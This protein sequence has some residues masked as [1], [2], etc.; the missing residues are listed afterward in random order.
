MPVVNFREVTGFGEDVNTL[1]S[2]LLTK[3][4]AK[5]ACC[6]GQHGYISG[7]VEFPSAKP[8]SQS[9]SDGYIEVVHN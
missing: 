7:T 2:T 6:R 9:T 8:C 5:S 3:T 4:C 1:V